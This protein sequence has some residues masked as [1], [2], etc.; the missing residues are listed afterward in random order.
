MSAAP[1]CEFPNPCPVCGADDDHAEWRGPAADPPWWNFSATICPHPRE[2]GHGTGCTCMGVSRETRQRQMQE[3]LSQPTLDQRVAALE[4][5]LLPGYPLRPF[6]MPPLTEKQEAELR[7]DFDETMHGPFTHRAL[8]WPPPLTPDEV[9]Q[10]LRESVTV[11]K[12]GEVLFFTMGDPDVTPVQL[13]EINEAV[14][15]WLEY[16]APDVKALVLPHGSM[17]AA[18]ALEPDFLKDCRIDIWRAGPVL[19]R[20]APCSVR[21]TH[22]PTGVTAEAPGDSELSARREA[23]RKLSASLASRGDITINDGRRALGLPER[24]S[25]LFDAAQPLPSD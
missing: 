23:T 1:G 7:R 3:A 2:P 8:P 25:P 21:I 11:V 14:S 10:L 6:D 13:R 18:E 22:L 9:R 12:P 20:L 5:T 16:N 4:A 17:A 15:A 24:E 19:G